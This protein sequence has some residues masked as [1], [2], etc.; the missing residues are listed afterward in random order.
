MAATGTAGV[1]TPPVDADVALYSP[2]PSR[3]ASLYIERPRGLVRVARPTK[4]RRACLVPRGQATTRGQ[5][6]TIRLHQQLTTRAANPS[7]HRFLTAPTILMSR[8]STVASTV[9]FCTQCSLPV[10][11]WATSSE[12]LRNP[13][14]AERLGRW[15]RTK[16]AWAR[17]RHDAPNPGRGR[18]PGMEAAMNGLT[19]RERP[20]RSKINLHQPEELKYWSHALG[21]SKEKICVAI[22]KVGNSAA[23]VRKELGIAPEG[24][25][26]AK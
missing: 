6:S 9:H 15:A 5:L 23:A 8:N 2:K 3:I 13:C 7:S 21:V 25:T 18:A 24:Q 1:G 20:D 22:E 16:L 26:P 17:P 19:R 12:G 4:S 14:P 10:S 11:V